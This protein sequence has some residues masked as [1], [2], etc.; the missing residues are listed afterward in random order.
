MLLFLSHAVIFYCIIHSSCWTVRFLH[1]RFWFNCFCV[2]NSLQCILC[3]LF[4]LFLRFNELSFL[5]AV[6][7]FFVVTFV[8]FFVTDKSCSSADSVCCRRNPGFAAKTISYNFLQPKLSESLAPSRFLPVLCSM[9][10]L[11]CRCRLHLLCVVLAPRYLIVY[12]NSG[13]LTVLSTSLSGMKWGR[14]PS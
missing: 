9:R 7:V 10:R 8:V 13:R 12:F 3:F 2:L 11:L 14:F 5:N 6:I 4:V 1:F